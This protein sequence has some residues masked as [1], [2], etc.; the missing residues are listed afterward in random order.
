M[1][2]AELKHELRESGV[3]FQKMCIRICR[4]T[5]ALWLRIRMGIRHR[6]TEETAYAI[7]RMANEGFWLLCWVLCFALLPIG[8]FK[9][10][11]FVGSF[12]FVV[13]ASIFRTINVESKRPCSK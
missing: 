2:K 8:L 9:P 5:R 4:N 7:F 1:N 6:D 3:A 10:A 13:L 11:C 12:A